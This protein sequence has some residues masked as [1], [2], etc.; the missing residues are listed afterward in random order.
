MFKIRLCISVLFPPLFYNSQFFFIPKLASNKDHLQ[1]KT[2]FTRNSHETFLYRHI[3]HLDCHLPPQDMEK[4]L[5]TPSPGEA[6]DA[7]C[8]PLSSV[9]VEAGTGAG[10]WWAALTLDLAVLLGYW[11]S[12]GCW[13]RWGQCG[14]AAGGG[15]AGGWILPVL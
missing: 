14:F 6:E 9:P 4:Q 11:G 12:G 15:A 2:H 7:R 10:H 3:F 1:V 13:H 8:A 5:P